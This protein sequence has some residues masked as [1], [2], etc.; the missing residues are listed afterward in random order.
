MHSTF[1][2]LKTLMAMLLLLRILFQFQHVLIKIG[3]E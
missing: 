1:G 2:K 3:H